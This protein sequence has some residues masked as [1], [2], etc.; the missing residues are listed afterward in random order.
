MTVIKFARAISV[1][2]ITSIP[3][4]VILIP[5]LLACRTA[6]QGVQKYDKLVERDEF[7]SQKWSD[8]EAQLQRRSDLIPNLVGVVKGYAKHEE[9]TLTKVMEAR[10]GATQIKMTAADLENPEKMAAFE[11][12]QAKLKGSLSRLMMVKEAYPE[13]KANQMFLNL[14]SQIEGTENRILRSRQEYNKAVSAFNLEVRRVSGKVIN[15]I[16]GNEFKPRPFFQA[17]EAAKTAP[18]VSF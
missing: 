17:T 14:Q 2:L 4:G 15:P 8:Y 13:L 12:A 3:S 18:A 6:E 1:A 7:C 16:T 9:E 10:A 11:A 5:A